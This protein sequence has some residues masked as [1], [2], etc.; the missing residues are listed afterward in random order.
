MR[1][2]ALA[3]ALAAPLAA[4]AQTTPTPTL[5]EPSWTSFTP[6]EG[7]FSVLMPAAPQRRQDVTADGPGKG[8][9]NIVYF[10]TVA[11]SIY[12]TAWADYPAS[13]NLDVQ[14]ELAANRDNFLK[15]IG[16]TMTSTRA[17]S[18]GANPGLEFTG[19][20]AGQIYV[21]GRVFLVGR[22]PMLVV[23]ATHPSRAGSPDIP[24]FLDSFQPK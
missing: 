10:A 13:V 5:T 12:M 15:G 17:R 8:A 23:I 16:A 1:I 24:R 11:G 3:L 20:K 21:S 2:I 7:H 18:L 14:G 19:E 4:Q 6:Q 9:V 22:R